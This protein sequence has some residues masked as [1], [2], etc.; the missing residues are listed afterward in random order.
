MMK[1]A[2]C[3]ILQFDNLQFDNWLHVPFT[4]YNVQFGLRVVEVPYPISE[5]IITLNS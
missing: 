1:F 3:T 2:A 5:V 4:M